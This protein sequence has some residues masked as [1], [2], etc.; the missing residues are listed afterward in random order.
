[1]GGELFIYGRDWPTPDGTGIRDYIH[2]QDLAEG[3]VA[4]LEF[5]KMRIKS[6]FLLFLT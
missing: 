4:A 5:L 2:V 6:H 3:H 1:M